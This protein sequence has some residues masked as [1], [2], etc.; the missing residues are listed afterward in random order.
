VRQAARRY[1][2]TDN[3]V[4]VVL[5]PELPKPAPANSLTPRLAP[6]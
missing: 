2:D 4:Q 6:Q 5:N 3:Y 1:F